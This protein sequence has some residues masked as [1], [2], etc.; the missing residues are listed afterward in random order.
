MEGSQVVVAVKMRRISQFVVPV[1]E[2]SQVV[3]AI[4]M[5]RISQ[6]VIPAINEDGKSSPNLTG[7]LMRGAIWTDKDVR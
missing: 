3:V 4:K 5:R 6:V 2:G 7:G 1:M